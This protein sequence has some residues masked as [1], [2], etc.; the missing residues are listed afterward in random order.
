MNLQLLSK[1]FLPE[2]SEKKLFLNIKSIFC[3]YIYKITM[4]TLPPEIFGSIP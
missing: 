4:F 2:V 1:I 3:N